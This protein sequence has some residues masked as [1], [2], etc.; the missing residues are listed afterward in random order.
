MLYF[1][2]R[3]GFIICRDKHPE[4]TKGRELEAFKEFYMQNKVII[5]V[6]VSMLT[7]ILSKLRSP[8]KVE[9]GDF[10]F[11]KHLDT[12]IRLYSTGQTAKKQR[13]QAK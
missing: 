7:S 8:A 1:L 5:K 11:D 12:H 4:L 2:A 13:N 9:A 10:A 6:T 3:I